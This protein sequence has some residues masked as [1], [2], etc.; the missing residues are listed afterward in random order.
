M[1]D[2]SLIDD[3]KELIKLGKGDLGRL[4]HIKDT[5]ENKKKCY[6]SDRKYV[7]KLKEV[8]ISTTETTIQPNDEPL[9]HQ[10]KHTETA[11]NIK[12]THNNNSEPVS[13]FWACFFSFSI[14]GLVWTQKMKKTRKWIPIFTFV[15]ITNIIDRILW[16]MDEYWNSTNAINEIIFWI[17]DLV[18]LG[19]LGLAIYFMLRWTTE[20]NLKVF[21][22]KSK[23][24]WKR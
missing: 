17:Y 20:Y 6:D 7:Q 24:E 14:F 16:H 23:K 4:E 19:S 11:N 3:V 21:G 22:Y 9:K 1:T 10:V 5:L 13:R 8:H 2:H 12:P 18:S 15:M